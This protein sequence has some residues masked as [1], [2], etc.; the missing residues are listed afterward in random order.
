VYEM[1]GDVLPHEHGYPLRLLVPD[2]YGMKNPKWLVGLRLMK[3]DFN[4]WYGQRNWSKTAIVQT[5]S[6]IDSPAPDAVLPPGTQTVAGIAFAGSRGI[7]RVE[8]SLDDG[9][10]WRSATLSVSDASQNRWV[11]WQGTFDLAPGSEVRIV[12]RATDGAGGLQTE[13]FSLPEPDGGT[14]WP[15]SVVRAA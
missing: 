14:G 7:Q 9:T 10:S 12:A 13:A 4:D 11:A 6:R 8:Y 15:H 2:R 5:M 1:N 3:R